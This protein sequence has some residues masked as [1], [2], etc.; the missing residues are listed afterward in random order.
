MP[1]EQV[2]LCVVCAGARVDRA[3]GPGLVSPGASGARFRPWCTIPSSGWPKPTMGYQGRPWRGSKRPCPG[4]PWATYAESSGACN[5]CK[6]RQKKPP[7]R[8]PTAGTLSMCP[9]AAPPPARSGAGA[10]RSAVR[11]SQR[12]TSACVMDDSSAP[13]P[14]GMPRTVILGERCA[15]PNIT[16]HLIRCLCATNSGY[17]KCQNDRMLPRKKKA[18][19]HAPPRASVS[20]HRAPPNRIRYWLLSLFRQGES[21]W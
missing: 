21:A 13:V 12:R 6:R 2:R 19:F 14:G 3:T 11:G 18:T 8:W 16:A 1:E 17:E 9:E 4:S 7:K 15:V 20:S 10:L 5:G